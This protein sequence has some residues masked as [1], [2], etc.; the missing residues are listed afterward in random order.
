MSRTVYTLPQ[1]SGPAVT[2]VTAVDGDADPGAYAVQLDA[3]GVASLSAQLL[4]ARAPYVVTTDGDDVLIVE[5]DEVGWTIML[6][7]LDVDGVTVWDFGT[8]GLPWETI[9][10]APVAAHADD[11]SVEPSTAA[12]DPWVLVSIR[13]TDDEDD[14]DPRAHIT[15]SAREAHEVAADLIAAAVEAEAGSA[16]P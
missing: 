4:A 14:A 15:L 10:A 11:V 5:R 6:E 1:P 13:D 9:D 7:P 16:T 2:V 12:G 3:L 8:V